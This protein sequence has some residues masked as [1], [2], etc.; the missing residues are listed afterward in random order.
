MNSGADDNTR[1]HPWDDEIIVNH[2]RLLIDSY[3]T[4]VGRDLLKH[5]RDAV[6][7][8]KE[9]Y[10]APFVLVSAGTEADPI[11]N[12]GNAAAL[13]LWEMSW[14]DLTSTPGRKTAEP[15]HRSERAHFLAEVQSKGFIDNYSGIRISSTGK[16]FRI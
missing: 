6:E 4:V 1:I 7:A 15:M 9:L 10:E 2:S 13:T 3:Q 16:R 8:A 5:S 12:Y 11:L 14:T